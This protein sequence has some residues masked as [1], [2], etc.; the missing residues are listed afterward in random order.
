MLVEDGRISQCRLRGKLRLDKRRILPGDKVKVVLEGDGGVVEEILPRRCVMYRPPVANVNQA[1]IVQAVQEPAPNS[2][3]IDRLLVLAE[4]AGM[5]AIVVFN[6]AD[7]GIPPGTEQL[8]ETYERTGY[9]VVAT[10]IKT[11]QGI[12]ELTDLLVGKV[13]TL[14]G[15]SGVGKSSLI[16]AILPDAQLATGEVSERL[17]RGKHTTRHVELLPLTRGGLL[18]DTPGFSQLTLPH[19]D[20]TKLQELFVEFRIPAAN[21]RF[22]GCLHSREPEC[23]V[24]VAVEQGDIARSRFDNYLTLLEEL[25]DNDHKRY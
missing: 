19:I 2:L 14:A 3:L 12:S 15:L 6:K 24:R 17:G 18:A 7:K 16:N 8:M 20:K 10:S 5:D 23:A 11:G 21:C 13:S 4:E 22:S 1:V 25:A 9:P